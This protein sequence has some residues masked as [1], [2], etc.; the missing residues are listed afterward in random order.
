[1]SATAQLRG[2]ASAGHVI[3]LSAVFQRH[4]E[5]GGE[6]RVWV[7]NPEGTAVASIPIRLGAPTGEN[8]IITYGLSPG[9]RIVTAG[10][11]RL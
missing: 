2:T 9:Q 7:V 8:E 10:T 1:M 11:S 3:P 4:A 6:A 5:A